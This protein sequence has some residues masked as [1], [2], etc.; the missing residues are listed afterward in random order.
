MLYTVA[1]TPPTQAEL[2]ALFFVDIRSPIRS[3]SLRDPPHDSS[4]VVVADLAGVTLIHVKANKFTTQATCRVDGGVLSAGAVPNADAYYS[5]GHDS[6]LR[7]FRV[8]QTPNNSTARRK[9]GKMTE[10]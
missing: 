4:T 10:C 9:V 7:I 2:K 8:A 3:L 5:L 1:C 6:K